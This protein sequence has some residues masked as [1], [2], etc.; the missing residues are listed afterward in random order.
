M[1]SAGDHSSNPRRRPVSDWYVFF[2]DLGY[3]LLIFGCAVLILV[4]SPPEVSPLLRVGLF[5]FS[6]L[7]LWPVRKV[8]LGQIEKAPSRPF[9]ISLRRDR[10]IPGEGDTSAADASIT[11]FIRAIRERFSPLHVHLFLLQSDGKTFAAP[12]A[13]VVFSTD[14]DLARNLSSGTETRLIGSEPPADLFGDRA[15]LFTLGARAVAALRKDGRLAGFAVLGPREHDRTYSEDD[16]AQIRS[17]ANR[18]MDLEAQGKKTYADSRDL[19]LPLFRLIHSATDLDVLLELLH[20][21]S[22]RLVPAGSFRIALIEEPSSSLSYAFYFEDGLRRKA[23]EGVPFPVREDLAGEA[24]RTGQTLLTDDYS[25]ACRIRNLPQR[26][27]AAAWIG[28]PLRSGASVI[29]VLVLTRDVPFGEADRFLLESIASHA[30][31]AIARVT[32]QRDSRRRVELL[33][34]LL[35]GSRRIAGTPGG[36]PLF[37]AILS[38]A[39]E[40]LPCQGAFLLLPEPCGAW[41]IAQQSGLAEP[42]S[43]LPTLG[44]DHPFTKPS[45]GDRPNSIEFLPEEDPFFQALMECNSDFLCAV[46]LPLRRK[47]KLIGWIVLWNPVGGAALPREEQSLLQEYAM[48]AVLALESA[49]APPGDASAANLADELTSLQ[50]LDQELNGALD[51]F[52]AMAIVLDWAVRYT[53]STAGFAAGWTGDHFEVAAASGYPEGS[54]PEMRSRLPPEFGGLAEAA[55]SGRAI[56]RRA[57]GSASGGLLPGGKSVL[58]VPIRRN[59]QTTGA[60]FLESQLENAFSSAQAEFLERLAS[61][62]AIAI[63]SAQLYSE[64]RNANQ[65]KNEFISFVAHELKTPMTSIR[66]YTDLLAQGAVGP[67]TQPQANF[68]STIRLNADRMSALVSDLNDV[69]RIESGRLKLE[70]AAVV[71]AP[72]M[73]EVLDALRSQIESKEQKLTLE[74]PADLPPVWVDRGRLI[75][76]LTNL[77]SNA[78]KYTLAG[79]AFRIAAERCS[80]RWDPTGPPE[81]VH[82]LVQDTGLG[83]SP[84]EQ[85]HI[86][87]KFFRSEDRMVRDLPGTGLGLNITRNLVEMHGG[88][89]WFESELHKGSTFHFTIPVSSG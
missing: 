83:I 46:S 57:D 22:L 26:Q 40:L 18:A 61:H 60:L 29:G 41:A 55:Q 51:P 12:T 86:F 31:P 76:I 8:L 6:A 71:L 32:L 70:F 53:E 39:R 56:L 89:I 25:E 17:W 5:I 33:E 27:P 36:E 16:L 1:N 47:E 66:G 73:D 64:V 77:V 54:Q 65:A 38:G 81:V 14:G 58:I 45:A 74:V 37:A 28:V 24:V 49:A 52:Q 43:G 63:A 19:L 44:L 67:V 78:Q 69:S 7:I 4:A 21:Q 15:R 79:G 72:A 82:I 75:Q 3:I 85:K 11:E 62:A 50:H 10:A 2:L 88:K 34:S 23:R 9:R 87:Q 68:L 42:I 20:V 30:G 48:V 35:R 84:Q 59:V 13:E 80:N